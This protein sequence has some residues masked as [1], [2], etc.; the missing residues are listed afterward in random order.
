MLCSSFRSLNT[1]YTV[2]GGLGLDMGWTIKM[3]NRLNISAISHIGLDY[4]KT[5]RF[6]SEKSAK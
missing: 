4:G 5:H 6:F 3:N 2:W 1:K